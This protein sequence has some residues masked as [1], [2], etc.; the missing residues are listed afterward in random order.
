MDQQ[1]VQ[2]INLILDKV[3]QIPPQRTGP[4]RP[5]PYGTGSEVAHLG[6]RPRG[7]H[8]GRKGNHKGGKGRRDTGGPSVSQGAFSRHKGQGK[9]EAKTSGRRN[10]DRKVRNGKGQ[11]VKGK[12]KGRGRPIP[13]K[14]AKGRNQYPFFPNKSSPEGRPNQT[15]RVYLRSKSRDEDGAPD[16]KETCDAKKD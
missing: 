6:W 5:N 13:G 11:Q 2:L 4:L 14:G 12:G 8:P 10:R 7:F 9:G 1:R 15:P 3:L 16:N